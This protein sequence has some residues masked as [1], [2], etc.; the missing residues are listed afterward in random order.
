ME[1]SQKIITKNDDKTKQKNYG[2]L[3]YFDWNLSI[4]VKLMF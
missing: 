1:E 2:P 4:Q 3:F